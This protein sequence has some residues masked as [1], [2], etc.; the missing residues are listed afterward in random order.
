MLILYYKAKVAVDKNKA[1]YIQLTNTMCSSD[2][3]ISLLCKEQR[4][5]RNISSNVHTYGGAIASCWSVWLMFLHYM[6]P[7]NISM[8]GCH[9]MVVVT[10]LP[11]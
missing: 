8:I 6:C 7:L 2:S 10:T 4:Q 9:A 11:W 1:K 5:V 3:K